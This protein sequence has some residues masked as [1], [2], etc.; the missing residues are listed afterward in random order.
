MTAYGQAKLD[1]LLFTPDLQVGLIFHSDR[2]SQYADDDFRDVLKDY[3]IAASMSRRG[4]C[5]DT[6]SIMPAVKRYS[7]R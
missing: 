6:Q 3:G 5:R 4:N 1:N 2:G 7:A